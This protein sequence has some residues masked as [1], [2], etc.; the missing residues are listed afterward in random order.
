MSIWAFLYLSWIRNCSSLLTWTDQIRLC[1]QRGSKNSSQVE[2]KADALIHLIYCSRPPEDFVGIVIYF[3][4]FLEAWYRHPT[5]VVLQCSIWLCKETAGH[6]QKTVTQVLAWVVQLVV[7]MERQ[8]PRWGPAD[9]AVQD[10]ASVGI[11]HWGS[12]LI[13][14]LSLAAVCKKTLNV[15][16]HTS[17]I[18]INTT[19]AGIASKG[20]HH[21]VY[22]NFF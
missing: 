6:F 22:W 16:F 2:W 9:P 10:R 17:E 8:K 12:A 20:C 13:H 7:S 11:W 19:N 14:S 1:L 18:S 15:C 3:C 5:P 21:H 4:V